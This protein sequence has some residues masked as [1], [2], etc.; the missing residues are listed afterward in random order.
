MPKSTTAA[1][2]LIFTKK[3][4]YELVMQ[5]YD[6]NKKPYERTQHIINTF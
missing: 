1:C 3:A 4:V 6:K 5:K 2:G